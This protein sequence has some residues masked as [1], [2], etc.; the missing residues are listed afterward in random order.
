MF[1][2]IEQTNK[3]TLRHAFPAL[4]LKTPKVSKINI[5]EIFHQ[6]YGNMYI[7]RKYVCSLISS[8]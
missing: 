6:S 1:L 2:K 7:L 4:K 3:L 8:I 5:Q